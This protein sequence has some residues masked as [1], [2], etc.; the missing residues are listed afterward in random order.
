MTLQHQPLRMLL[1]RA[2]E[3][4]IVLISQNACHNIHSTRKNM[5]ESTWLINKS[6]HQSSHLAL[7]GCLSSRVLWVHSIHVPWDKHRDGLP[8]VGKNVFLS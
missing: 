6:R 5:F 7:E 2:N 3:N 8:L 4:K 1:T